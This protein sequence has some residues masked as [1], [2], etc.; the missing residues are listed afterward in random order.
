MIL[1]HKYQFVCLNP[2]KTGTGFREVL[3]ENY[4]DISLKTLD[5]KKLKLRH[6]SSTQA[7][8]YIKSINKDPN[9]YYWFTFVRNPWE[10]LISWINMRQNHILRKETYIRETTQDYNSRIVEIINKNQF[11][12]YI[13]RDGKLIDF[14]GSI[15][16]ITEDLGL[17][18]N[19]LN[20]DIPVGSRKDEYKKDFKDDIRDNMSQEVVEMIADVE[21]DVISLKGYK[22]KE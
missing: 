20:I 16:N 18:L 11:K 1:S 10:R 13:Y 19:K 7:S 15:E 14:I 2:P 3:L 21:E 9:D 17:V 4:S 22:F 8:D 6:W 12:D 5:G